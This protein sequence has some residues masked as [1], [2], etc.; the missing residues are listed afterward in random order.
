[1]G[2]Q[3]LGRGPDWVLSP[4]DGISTTSPYR[5]ASVGAYRKPGRHL[6][7]FMGECILVRLFMT[8]DLHEQVLSLT[9]FILSAVRR[10]DTCGSKDDWLPSCFCLLVF[11][12]LLLLIDGKV[13]VYLEYFYPLITII[14]CLHRYKGEVGIS[15]LEPDRIN[16]SWNAL[17]GKALRSHQ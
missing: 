17:W 15:V 9:I 2:P 4:A 3:D 11:W 1:M 10:E 8:G 12:K 13:G 14:F 6:T 5:V 16:F 7:V